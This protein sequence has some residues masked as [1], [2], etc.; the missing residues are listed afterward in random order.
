MTT[1]IASHLALLLALSLIVVVV[2]LLV[3]VLAAVPLAMAVGS[4]ALALGAGYHFPV[5]APHHRWQAC[6]RRPA[7]R[8]ATTPA[9]PGELGGPRWT[10]TWL[11]VPPPIQIPALR[12][13]AAAALA[14]WQVDG[15][16]AE[17]A[18]LVAT[19]LLTNALEY[20]DAPIQITLG[21]D[22]ALVRVQV[23]DAV[24]EP[25]RPH[26]HDPTHVRGHGLEIV[27]ALALRQGWT[28]DPHG[29]TVWA[30]VPTHWP[31]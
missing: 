19:E 11:T 14:E 28:P 8:W 21:L 18:L 5:P 23:H 24:A 26:P 20:A 31:K 1:M 3:M 6:T 13:Q 10:Q 12:E 30:D 17:P 27:A 16:A 25:P 4:M 15:Q 29:K 2:A 9:P 22:Q 7:P